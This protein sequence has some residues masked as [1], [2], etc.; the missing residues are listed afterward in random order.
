MIGKLK[1][2][3]KKVLPPRI[4][5]R[6]SANRWWKF[7][8]KAHKSSGRLDVCRKVISKNGIVVRFGPFAG[9]KLPPK[10]ILASGNC[11]TLVG[12]Y[13]MELHPWFQQLDFTQYE[14]LLDIGAAEGYYAVGMA[15]RA[16]SPVDAFDTASVAR[17]LC[18]STAKLNRVAHL[19][20]IH[21]FCSPQALL[22]LAG[23]RCFIL[24]DCEGYEAILF[25]E[26]VINALANSDLIVELHDG[27]APA[28][29]TRE[30][31]R[32]RFK[33]THSVQI[34]HFQPRDLSIFP[35]PALA[36]TLGADAIRAIREEGR[37][38][39]H[40][41]LVAT[42]LHHTSPGHHVED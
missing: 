10:C 26:D 7:S 15:L 4:L 35:D 18:R 12:T 2:S 8:W 6:I 34:V 22:Q 13:E 37:P 23:L 25:S 20:R 39:G 5:A 42:S 28:G 3:I 27:A 11:C 19:V 16:G 32:E 14:R 38:L 1:R 36:E 41:W 21:S 40:E 29:T 30:L 24:S 31:L 17:R 33:T 9:L